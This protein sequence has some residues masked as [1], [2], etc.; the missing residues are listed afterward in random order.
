[1]NQESSVDPNLINNRPCWGAKVLSS[2]RPCTALP[3]ASYIR[4]LTSTDEIGEPRNRGRQIRY[5]ATVRAADEKD[6]YYRHYLY[7][8]LVD[9]RS[10]VHSVSSYVITVFQ[11]QLQGGIL[12]PFNQ[13]SNSL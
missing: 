6:S 12:R 11:Q 8:F 2:V 5:I 13:D 10:T 3:G 9:L 4:R 7:N 1:M